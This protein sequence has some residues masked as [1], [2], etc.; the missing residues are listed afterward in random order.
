MLFAHLKRILGLGRLRFRR[1]N[2]AK[3]EFHLTATART[4]TKWQSSFRFP[5]EPQRGEQE[6]RWETVSEC[7]WA[8]HGLS[9]ST[10]SAPFR[11]SGPNSAIY[12][13]NTAPASSYWGGTTSGRSGRQDFISRLAPRA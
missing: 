8:E 7:V 13:T 6:E 3:D 2:R 5:V 12:I 4:F 9:F 11:S 10:Q 1:P